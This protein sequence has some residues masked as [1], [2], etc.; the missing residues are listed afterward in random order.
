MNYPATIVIPT[1]NRPAFLKRAIESAVNQTI[2]CEVIIVDHGSGEPTRSLV[3]GFEP[4][5]K[6]LRRHEDSG[7]EF[8]WLDGVLTASSENV[9]ILFDDDWLEPSFMEHALALLEPDVGFVFSVTNVL[10]EDGNSSVKLFDT[11]L[12]RTGIYHLRRDRRVVAEK[13]ISPSAIV[14]RRQDWIRGL[15][16]AGAPLQNLHYHGAG[17]DH[18]VKLLC[19]INYRKFGYIDAPLVNFQAHQGSITTAS[20]KDEKN[21]KNLKAV[22]SEVFAI[23]RLLSVIV[24]SRAIGALKLLLKIQSILRSARRRSGRF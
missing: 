15:H 11:L 6:Y 13:M 20:S 19:M 24:D 21:A 7:P 9:K 2:S 16:P 3:R 18:W 1:F 12:Q 17:A 10:Q 22:Y 4:R 14:M 23:Y 5:V 8:A